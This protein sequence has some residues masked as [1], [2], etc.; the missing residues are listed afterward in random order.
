MTFQGAKGLEARVVCVIGLEDGIIPRVS[1][2]DKI[3]EQSRLLFVTM[4]RAINELHLFHARK[5]SGNIIQRSIYN[6]EARPDLSRSRFIDAIN[7]EHLEECYH[8]P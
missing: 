7:K 1:D 3:E 5:R 2:A 4:T 6:K 8:R